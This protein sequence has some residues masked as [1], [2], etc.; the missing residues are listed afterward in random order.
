V[1][2]F[3]TS[4]V[5]VGQTATQLLSGLEGRY[6]IAVRFEA[7]TFGNLLLGDSSLTD[8]TGFAIGGLNVSEDAPNEELTMDV[9]LDST[10]ELYAKIP[11]SG[12]ALMTVYL[13]V[14]PR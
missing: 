11:G 9:L 6:Q 1:S 5:T 10:D 12:P 3:Q 14:N 2:A 7:G 13:M 8:A 4:Q